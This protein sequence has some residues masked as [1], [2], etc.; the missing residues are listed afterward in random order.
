[1]RGEE[2]Y[3]QVEWAMHV[4]I[5]SHPEWY[6]GLTLTSS[7]EEFQAR[8]HNINHGYC[9]EPC[10]LPQPSAAPTGPVS[11]PAT[12][13]P[14]VMACRRA[15]RGEECYEQV[16]WAMHV[17]IMSHP[18]WYPG[19]TQNSSFEEVQARLHNINHGYCPE[20][21]PS[22]QP[23]AAPTKKKCCGKSGCNWN[24]PE[25]DPAIEQCCGEGEY[26]FAPTVCSKDSGCC[27]GRYSA[28]PRCYDRGSQQCCGVNE[29]N[30]MPVVCSSDVACPPE[31]NAFRQC[32][33][34]TGAGT[35]AV[36][37]SNTAEAGS[38]AFL[39]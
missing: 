38:Q 12:T 29:P 31:S 33:A 10:L 21:C 27:P 5:V 25:Y 13:E 37:S 11:T 3:E 26:V 23:S 32:P 18:E 1:V 28:S 2:C 24:S 39:P 8:L 17:G 36:N 9:P 16:E 30:E 20:P 7:F 14:P 22:L 35:T 4:G 19:L 15:V 34:A 6:P